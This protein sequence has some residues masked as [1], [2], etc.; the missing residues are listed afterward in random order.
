MIDFNLQRLP[1]L[2]TLG[3][4]TTKREETHLD[5]SLLA[6]LHSDVLLIHTKQTSDF[7]N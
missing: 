6:A 1:M 4:D 3:I 7:G 5:V 2:C